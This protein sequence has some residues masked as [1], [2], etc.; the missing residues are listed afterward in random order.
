M[1]P[2]NTGKALS[3][4]VGEIRA[5]ALD[6]EDVAVFVHTGGLPIIF[7]YHVPLKEL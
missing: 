5:G 2:V 6:K 7:A 4:L 1:D 3:G